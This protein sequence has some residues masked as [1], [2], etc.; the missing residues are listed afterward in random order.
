MQ[1]SNTPACVLQ[2][3]STVSS[4]RIR[5]TSLS[6]MSAAGRASEY[7]PFVPRW[8]VAK[9]ALF[10]ICTAIRLTETMAIANTQELSYNVPRFTHQPKEGIQGPESQNP[11]LRDAANEIECR[12]KAI[13]NDPMYRHFVRIPGRIIGCL[14]Y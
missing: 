13:A 5:I 4:S 3:W 1:T 6:R 8:A 7:P 11:L 12:F 10:K 9:P 2:K 14:D